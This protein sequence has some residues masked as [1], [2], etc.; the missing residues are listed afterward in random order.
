M[1]IGELMFLKFGIVFELYSSKFFM[2][3]VILLAF[4]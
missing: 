1:R 3:V 4:W 2:K